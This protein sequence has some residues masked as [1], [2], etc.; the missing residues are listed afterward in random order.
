[1]IHM[2]CQALFFFGKIVKYFRMSSAAV[3][4]WRFKEANLN[5]ELLTKLTIIVVT[6]FY[7]V[8]QC[9]NAMFL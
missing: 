2:K 5:I 7:L 1:M 4:D 3:V 8:L 9:P 6:K